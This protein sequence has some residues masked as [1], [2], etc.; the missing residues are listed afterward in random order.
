VLH[1]AWAV[2]G[3]RPRA[4]TEEQLYCFFLYPRGKNSVPLVQETGWTPR[5]V[6]A[7]AGNLAPNGIRSSDCTA[8]NEPLHRLSYGGLTEAVYAVHNLNLQFI[9]TLDYTVNI[10]KFD[11]IILSEALKLAQH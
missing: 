7:D 9:L 8:R 4:G 3:Q 11:S 1:K 6:W 5:P 2:T 10:Y